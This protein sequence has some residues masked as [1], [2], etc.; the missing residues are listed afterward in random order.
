MKLLLSLVG[1]GATQDIGY[2]KCTQGCVNRNRNNPYGL[3]RCQKWCDYGAP[4]TACEDGI[5]LNDEDDTC[6][7]FYRCTNGV[8]LD[9]EFCPDGTRFDEANQKCSSTVPCKKTLLSECQKHC[10]QWVDR[11][12][13]AFIFEEVESKCTLYNELGHIEYDEDDSKKIMGLVDGCL[14]CFRNGWDYATGSKIWSFLKMF[15]IYWLR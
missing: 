12:S 7:S 6:R 3:L 15:K 13:V 9:I 1:I 8:K 4:S 10:Q 11:G 2:K 5:H 14:N